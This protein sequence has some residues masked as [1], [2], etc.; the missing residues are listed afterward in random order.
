MLQS[1]FTLYINRYT[2]S[3]IAGLNSSRGYVL[4]DGDNIIVFVDNRYYER[5]TKVALNWSKMEI[6]RSQGIDDVINYLHTHNQHRLAVDFST[7][8]HR[9]A[10]QIITNGI[11]LE[12]K[13]EQQLRLVK[14]QLE[15]ENLQRLALITNQCFEQLLPTI[16]LGQSECEVAKNL[17]TILTNNG[18]DCESFPIIVAFG[19][20]SSDPHHQP[21][22]KILENNTNVLID[23]GGRLGNYNTDLTRNFYVGNPPPEYIKL[24]QTVYECQQHILAGQYSKVSE[25][26]QKANK[27]FEKSGNLENYLHNLGH[28]I[29][30]EV[31]EYPDL[32]VTNNSQVVDNML[33][34]IE[35]GLYLPTKF[36]VRIED[37]V[38]I[39]QQQLVPMTASPKEIICLNLD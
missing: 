16:K 9:L 10:T 17:V 37:M 22:K 31:H 20:N 8:N 3:Y 25:L 1:K 2:K 36:G 33:V 29:G 15:I 7:I 18:F 11:E 5:M 19:A 12:D 13:S 35:P 32:T 6:V 28:G 38:V 21:S 30:Y 34:T 26:Q 27:F 23:F 4:K 39:N 24:Y 14:T